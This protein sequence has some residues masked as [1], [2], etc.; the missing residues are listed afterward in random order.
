MLYADDLNYFTCYYS[1]VETPEY[2]T[3]LQNSFTSGFIAMNLLLILKNVQF[4]R[5]YRNQH[6]L[7]LIIFWMVI[8]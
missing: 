2:Y 6:Q 7:V 5:L 1:T 3:L 8:Y 4:F